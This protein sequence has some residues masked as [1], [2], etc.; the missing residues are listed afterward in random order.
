MRVDKATIAAEEKL[1]GKFLLRTSD[2]TLTAEDIALGY[3]QL[4]EVERG[5]R[6]I[7]STLELRPVYHHLE[8]RIRAHVLLGWLALL[9]IRVA[10]TTTEDTWRNLR[11]EL[12]RIHLGTF[13]SPAGTIRR[14]TNTTPHKPGSRMID[15]LLAAVA[16]EL[17]DDAG[18]PRP[19]W[20][21]HVPPL[22]EP[23]HPPRARHVG[24][25]DV[26]PQLVARGLMIDTRSLWRDP[27]TLGV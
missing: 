24:G 13:T 5:W 1:D 19:H 11:N 22:E 21:T 16:E 7:K 12:D 9:L 15:S 27:E 8:H 23:Y 6:D 18:L 26:A 10:E 20:T 3:K 2:P 14:R 25:L 17:A 4:L